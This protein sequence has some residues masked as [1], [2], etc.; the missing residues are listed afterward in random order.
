[1]SHENDSAAY[2][3]EA[4]LSALFAAYRE[5]CP[6]PDPSANFTPELWARIEARQTFV[7]SLKRF[8]QGIITAAAAASLVMGA[9]LYRPDTYTNSPV[10]QTGYLELLANEQSADNPANAEIVQALYE[11]DR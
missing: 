1:M 2:N 3:R 4:E 9:Y 8:A 5:A 7:F 6:D 11:R 10:Y